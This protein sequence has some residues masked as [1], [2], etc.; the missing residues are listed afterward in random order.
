MAGSRDSLWGCLFLLIL[1]LLF[2]AILHPLLWVRTTFIFRPILILSYPLLV[3][4]AWSGYPLA[5]YK[6]TG[7]K[8]LR[9]LPPNVH[10]NVSGGLSGQLYS[11]SYRYDVDLN[12]PLEERGFTPF[13]PQAHE[14]FMLGEEPTPTER[15]Q[16][17]RQRFFRFLFVIAIIVLSEAWLMGLGTSWRTIFYRPS[18]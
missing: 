2:A 5:Y 1:C 12:A 8:F 11:Y 3:I 17:R 15:L 16:L 18:E 4:I 10:A 9:D 14:R 7:R 13:H 6:I